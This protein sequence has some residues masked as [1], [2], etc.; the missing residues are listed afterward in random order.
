M[1][2][3]IRDNDIECS[4]LF[5]TFVFQISKSKTNENIF[6]QKWL[7]NERIDVSKA[8]TRVKG[9]DHGSWIEIASGSLVLEPLVVTVEGIWSMIPNSVWVKTRLL[10]LNIPTICSSF[11]TSPIKC[12][13]QLIIWNLLICYAPFL[14][15]SL[16]HSI[17]IHHHYRYTR[18]TDHYILLYSYV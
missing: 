3:V 2:I 17:S 18:I 8:L 6:N 11:P 4:F 1:M 10:H 13:L 15:L 12:S 5:S 14:Q 7:S 16:W 9:S